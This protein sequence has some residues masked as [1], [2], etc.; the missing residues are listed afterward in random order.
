LAC[1]IITGSIIAAASAAPA[2]GQQEAGHCQPCQEQFLPS[3]P[4]LLLL[5][6]KVD[7][8]GQVSE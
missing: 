3:F 2:P 5:E 8:N 4:H 6:I 7:R 1:D